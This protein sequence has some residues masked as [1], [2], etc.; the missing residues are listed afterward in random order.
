MTVP[1]KEILDRMGAGV[2]YVDANDCIAYAND[3]AASVWGLSPKALTD[4]QIWSCHP[5]HLAD[6]VRDV[7]NS[8]R[9]GS[10]TAATW[11]NDQRSQFVEHW[12]SPIFDA[13]GYYSGAVLVT[14]DV[15]TRESVRQK[16]ETMAHTDTATGMLNR[17]FF[18][19]IFPAYQQ[20]LGSGLASLAVLMVDI[21]G[22]KRT[23]DSLGHAVGDRLIAK[24]G[25]IIKSCVRSSDPVF[26]VGG[27]EFT[28]LLPGGT[29]QAARNAYRRIKS[30][31]RRWSLAHPD[32][33]LSL[34]VGWSTAHTAEEASNMLAQADEAMYN[35]KAKQKPSDGDI[36]EPENST[37]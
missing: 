22:L 14:I 28:A 17:N 32:L 13:D 1:Y 16:Y 3:L 5:E 8:F 24:A 37:F 18:Q 31:C 33:P 6:G 21:N 25:E 34:S 27:D 36:D 10:S 2:V 29:R 11:M 26:R 20:R 19:E 9:S 4:R 15:T 35:D 23:N 12:L 30:A 7:L